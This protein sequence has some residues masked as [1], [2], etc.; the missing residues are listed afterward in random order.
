MLENL[1]SAVIGAILGSG[2]T[3]A[4]TIKMVSKKSMKNN[5]M[6]VEQSRINAGGDVAGRDIKKSK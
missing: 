5:G 6:I 2:V 3:Y 1:I 4:V